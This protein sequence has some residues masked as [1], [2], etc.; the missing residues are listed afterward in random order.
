[1][2]TELQSQVSASY[3]DYSPEF[4]AAALAAY[5]ANGCNLSGTAKE[6]NIPFQ[7]L[8]YWIR[9]ADRNSQ[10]QNAVK[11]DLASE[12]EQIAYK[13]T[14]IAK[15]TLDDPVKAA[16]IPFAALMTGGAVAIDKMLLLRNQPTSITLHVERTEISVMLAQSLADE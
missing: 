14:G 4:K 8:D 9:T 13:V 11:A 2:S 1:M 10:F 12:C 3:R 15:E 7:T 16:K 5:E 6:L